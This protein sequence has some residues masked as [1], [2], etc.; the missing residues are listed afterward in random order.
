MKV[1]VESDDEHFLQDSL[2][3]C[4]IGGKYINLL[5][6]IV[7]FIEKALRFTPTAIY[8]DNIDLIIQLFDTL[9]EFV[10]VSIYNHIC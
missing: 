10:A 9:I 6:S 1:R 4:P 2:R 3:K 8:D 5:A 7:D